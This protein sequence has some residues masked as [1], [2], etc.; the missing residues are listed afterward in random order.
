MA[1][2]MRP[3]LLMGCLL[4]FAL[5]IV[6]GIEASY[7]V[8]DGMMVFFLLFGAV[9]IIRYLVLLLAAI[10]DRIRSVSSDDS[11]WAPL[12]SIIVPAFNE[13]SLIGGALGSLANLDYPA[14]E[15]IVIDD[16]S[17]DGTARIARRVADCYPEIRFRIITQANAGKSW[18]L[19]TGIMHA[20]GEFVLCVD[21]DSKLDSQA[22]KAGIRHFIDRRVGAIGGYVDI[23]N[24]ENLVTRLQQLEYIIGLNFLRRG[25]SFFNIVTVVPGPIGL[26]RK[27]AIR[28]AGG[29]N[30]SGDCFAEDAEL[31]VRLLQKGWRVRGEIQ[32]IAHTE[33]PDTL[34][35]LLRQRYRWKRGIFQAW[36]DNVYQL[37]I[38][39]RR[40][41]IFIAGILTFESFLFEIV[42]F[43][44]T[45]FALAS[46][47]AFGELRIFIW[48]FSILAVLDLLVFLFANHEQGRLFYRFRLFV[49]SKFTYAYFLQALGVFALIDE[50]LSTG[51]QWDKLERTGNSATKGVL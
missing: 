39:P 34:Y 35:R 32:M 38:S 20:Q 8:H 26:F 48:A 17:T 13:E 40:D 50:W 28:E 44:I 11:S 51:M 5:C 10:R 30:T 15:I 12:V 21:S 24:T 4:Y 1:K 14:F 47:L 2:L 3:A 41:G 37:L 29:Y 33:A 19:N 22:L 45:L 43:G 27:E 31:T 7:V 16:G 18:A 25:L 42:N 6:G 46:F 36:I 9:V 49:L 23:V